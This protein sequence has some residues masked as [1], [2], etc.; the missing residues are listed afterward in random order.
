LLVPCS[1]LGI[2]EFGRNYTIL[3][4]VAGLLLAITPSILIRYLADYIMKYYMLI[5]VA[6]FIGILGTNSLIGVYITYILVPVF[7]NPRNRI[8]YQPPYPVLAITAD[9]IAGVREEYR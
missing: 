8:L 9:A 6:L 5:L 3:I 2:F 7:R 4:L 1:A